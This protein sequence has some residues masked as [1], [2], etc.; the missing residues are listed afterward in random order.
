MCG[1]V[2]CHL[3]WV[4]FLDLSLAGYLT[5]IPGFLFIT[6]VWTLSKSLSSHLVRLFPLHFSTYLHNFYCRFRIIRVLGFRLD[7]TPLFYFFSSLKTQWP[8]SAF[9]WCW[10]N[11]GN[12][13]L[14]CRAVCC[15][16]RHLAAEEA[17]AADE[18]ALSSPEG[19]RYIVADDGVTVYSYPWRLYSIYHECGKSLFQCRAASEPCSYQPCIQSDGISCQAE[20]LKAVPFYGSC[21]GRPVF[22]DMLEPAGAGGQTEETDSVLQPADSLHTLFNTQRPDVLFVILESFPPG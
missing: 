18:T 3:A 22:K 5:A 19:V 11:C 8:V 2:Q 21:G 13:C 1:L 17:V 20:G 6:S 15:F 14:C 7:A 16:L 9:G 12:G 4:T 10:G